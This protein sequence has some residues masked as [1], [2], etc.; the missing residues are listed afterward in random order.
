MKI[1]RAGSRWLFDAMVVLV[2]LIFFYQLVFAPNGLSLY[3]QVCR[4][5]DA[6]QENLDRIRYEQVLIQSKQALLEND[7]EFL[8]REARMAWGYVKPGEQLI[9][10]EKGDI[11]AM[12]EH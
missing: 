7:P 1:V 9:W 12:E 5:R 10:Y 3:F 11:H 6:Q 4:L 2:F 8:E